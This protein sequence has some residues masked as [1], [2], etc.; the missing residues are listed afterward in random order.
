MTAPGTIDGTRSSARLTVAG[1]AALFAA[2]APFATPATAASF[3]CRTADRPAE[4]AIC[5]TPDISQLDE[6]MATRYFEVYNAIGYS[7]RL[8]GGGT[9]VAVG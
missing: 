2:L 5:N 4:V 1:L 3:N 8:V 9:V 6:D 7:A